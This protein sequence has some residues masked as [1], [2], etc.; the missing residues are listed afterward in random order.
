MIKSV[1]LLCSADLTKQLAAF[2]RWLLRYHAPEVMSKDA[3]LQVRSL[4]I[5]QYRQSLRSWRMGTITYAE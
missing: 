4:V 5:D 1:L 3:G 2:E